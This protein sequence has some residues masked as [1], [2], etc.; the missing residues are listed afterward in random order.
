MLTVVAHMTPMR[1]SLVGPAAKRA[2]QSL[3]LGRVHAPRFFDE[4][5]STMFRKTTLL[6]L[7]V[8]GLLVLRLGHASARTTGVY[9]TND[10]DVT[11][12]FQ[13]TSADEELDMYSGELTNGPIQIG[14]EGDITLWNQKAKVQ[15]KDFRFTNA[16]FR[17]YGT[18]GSIPKK[19]C[20]LPPEGLSYSRR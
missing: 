8:L 14:G 12:P 10:T 1:R 5:E 7:V 18:R 19:G 16:L 9:I 2:W 4:K 15:S 20:R 13:F 6:G 17:I 11:M 3:L